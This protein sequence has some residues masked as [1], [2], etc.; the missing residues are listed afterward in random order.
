MESMF[1]RSVDRQMLFLNWEIDEIASAL[2]G[3]VFGIS[4]QSVVPILIGVGMSFLYMRTKETTME[5]FL[6]HWLYRRG[7]ISSKSKKLAPG[8]V[9]RFLE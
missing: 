4:I 6:V 5:N 2:I 8:Y 1:P 3:L 9:T 7:V